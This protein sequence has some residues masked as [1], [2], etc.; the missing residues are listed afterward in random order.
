MEMQMSN[1]MEDIIKEK[2][3]TI[4]KSMPDACLCERCT[5]DRLAYALNHMPPKY[6]VSTKG[7]LYAKINQ[8]QGQFN[9]D[10]VRAVTEAAV[11][12]AETPRH[13]EEN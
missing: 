6:V 7:K 4:L 5:L 1:Y 2:M 13:E 12:I 3:E 9:V 11:K 10:V 8:L